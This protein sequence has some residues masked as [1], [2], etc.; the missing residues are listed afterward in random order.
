VAKVNLSWRNLQGG[1]LPA[2]K[3]SAKSHRDACKTEE[4]N[5]YTEEK[6]QVMRNLFRQCAGN[7][8]AAL[9][10]RGAQRAILFAEKVRQLRMKQRNR[11]TDQ[12]ACKFHQHG[13]KLGD[14]LASIHPANGLGLA[15]KSL[16]PP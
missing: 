1:A 6:K 4:C 7:R 13:M 15:A 3:F 2:G 14:R 8:D 16:G 11:Q 5:P 12:D 9:A 10:E